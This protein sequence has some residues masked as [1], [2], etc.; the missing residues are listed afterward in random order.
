MRRR[1]AKVDNNQKEVV[2]EL[3]KLGL[4]VQSLAPLGG[5]VPDLLVGTHGKNYL[6]ELKD[7]SLC[8]SA[9]KLTPG[10]A[11]WLE[12]WRGQAQVATCWEDIAQ[13]VGATEG[14]NQ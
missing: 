12:S 2:A 4:S 10:E 7:G 14:G 11:A 1:A 13:A 8:P 9:R 5:G 6:F 3:R